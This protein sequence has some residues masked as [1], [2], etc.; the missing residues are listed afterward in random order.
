MAGAKEADHEA[1]SEAGDAGHKECDDR[2]FEMGPRLRVKSLSGALGAEPA[3]LRLM[4][5]FV[6]CVR[7]LSEA[8]FDKTHHLSR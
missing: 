8:L 2:H 7:V 4:G 6:S 3:M 5:G 1:H